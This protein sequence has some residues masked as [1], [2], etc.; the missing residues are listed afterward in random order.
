MHSIVHGSHFRLPMRIAD[1]SVY[2][3][4]HLCNANFCFFSQDS[5]PVHT[6]RH[7]ISI[8][9]FH[10][11]SNSWCFQNF[12]PSDTCAIHHL[13][14]LHIISLYGGA[15]TWSNQNS[16]VGCGDSLQFF[17][18]I[19]KAVVVQ[20]LPH[21]KFLEWKCQT[22]CSTHWNFWYILPTCHPERFYNFILSTVFAYF[23]S[24]MHSKS[25]FFKKCKFC[26]YL[27]LSFS[28]VAVFKF[29]F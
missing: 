19:T 2:L 1:Q 20:L 28:V 6:Q 15:I 12:W 27:I 10:M 5:V 3:T 7:Y 26:I 21:D 9:W 8:S 14:Y 13:K 25:S 24:Q 23:Y 17:C 16:G 4:F 29:I 11:P 22:K 18:F